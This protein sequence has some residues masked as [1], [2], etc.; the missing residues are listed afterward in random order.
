MNW[1]LVT[2]EALIKLLNRCDFAPISSEWTIRLRDTHANDSP[3]DHVG[4]YVERTTRRKPHL[5]SG[6]ID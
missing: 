2:L 3:A 6:L 5:G 4:N 1:H